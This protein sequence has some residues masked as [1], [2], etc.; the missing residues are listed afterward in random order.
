MQNFDVL[1]VGN[2][3]LALSTALA[4]VLEDAQLRVGILGSSAQVGGASTAAGAMLSS[5]GETTYACFESEYGKS[6]LELNVQAGKLWSDWI[7]ALNALLPSDH[8]LE[9][10]RG[11]CVLLNTES[12]RL[13][14]KNFSALIKAL[15]QYQEPF[16]EMDPLHIP[17]LNPVD[18]CRP[19]RALF[20]PREGYID[21]CRLLQ[22]LESILKKHFK[23]TFLETEA[24]QIR[25]ENSKIAYVETLRQERVWA[26]HVVLAAGA[27]S[28]HFIDQ[29]PELNARIPLILSGAGTACLI[30]HPGHALKGV[31]RTPTRAGA[32]GIHMMPRGSD[33]LYMGAS[34]SL[35]IYPKTF[36][37]MRDSH[38]LTKRALE[39]FNQDFHKAEITQWFVGNRPAP[40]DTFPLIGKT[41]I[42]GFWV[43]TGTYRDGLHQS[44]LLAQSLAKEII[45]TAS[46]S[47]PFPVERAL[48]Q[49]ITREQT[50]E[51]FSEHYMAV[52]YEH[53]IQ[54]PKLGFDFLLKEMLYKRGE[55]IYK[56]LDVNIGISFD[57]LIMLDLNRELIPT[58]RNYYHSSLS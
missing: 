18:N 40:I 50:L 8:F 53:G 45:G 22:A 25:V 14:N 11:T 27:Y 35:G 43:L 36:P 13:E 34:N 48:I 6:K 51:E 49:A 44:P 26:P 24:S 28:Q 5:F 23:V 55:E 42:V 54:L 20:L 9:I 52:G 17:G 16:E 38:Y 47:H 21:P 19:L 7:A 37:K 58:L 31:V 3:V 41:S 12:S 1:M 15:T 56:E 46:F 2:G 32:C 57:I 30:K 29:I 10:L 33:A 4:L 39:Q